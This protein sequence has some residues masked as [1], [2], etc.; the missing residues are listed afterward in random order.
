MS[1]KQGRLEPLII[2]E[3]VGTA[4]TSRLKMNPKSISEPFKLFQKAFKS[5]FSNRQGLNEKTLNFKK[6]QKLNEF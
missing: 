2:G 6:V 4:N 1:S 3:I 5:I